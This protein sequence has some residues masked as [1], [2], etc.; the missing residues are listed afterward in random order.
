MLAAC[1]A[2]EPDS[3][4]STPQETPKAVA[5]EI[6]EISVVASFYPLA[7]VTEAI[8]QDLATVTTIAA[9]SS[10][11]HDFELSPS[12]VAKIVSS[13]F[14]IYIPEF[15]PSFDAALNDLSSEQIIDATDG[16]TLLESDQDEHGHEEDDEHGHEEDD[17]HGHEED[18]E[19]G[20][21][22][23]DEHGHEEDDEHAHGDG[24]P[25]VWLNPLNMVTVAKQIAA[26]LTRAYPELAVELDLNL[27][28]FETQM[29][30]LDTSYKTALAECEIKTLLVS[31]EAFG[32]L[33]DQYGFTQLGISGIS[34]EAEPSPA[35]LAEVA[36][37]AREISATT[38]YYETKV[39]PSV[40]NA[41]AGEISIVTAVLDPIETKPEMGDYLYAMEQNLEALV[42]GQI[43]KA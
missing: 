21:E 2:T 41:L 35:R 9:G 29:I 12:D 28:N 8:V 4:S 3:T 25:H 36:K 11:P 31:H 13:D 14:A 19:H 39:D 6:N 26:T 18:D 40:A 1:S 33:V 7:Y 10:E 20:H 43:C 22:E 42:Q 5:N 37:V 30:E 23:D 38:I 17:E 15:M 27:A 16:I 24:D 32:Y 34:P